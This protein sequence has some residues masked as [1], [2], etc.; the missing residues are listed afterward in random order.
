VLRAVQRGD[1]NYIGQKI[2]GVEYVG[3]YDSNDT[4]SSYFSSNHGPGLLG[5]VALEYA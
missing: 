4:L 2:K 3:Y 1:L 5:G